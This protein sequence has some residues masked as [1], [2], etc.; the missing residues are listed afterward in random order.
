MDSTCLL[1]LLLLPLLLIG[2]ALGNGAQE[3]PGSPAPPE[4]NKA[5]ICLLSPD[6]GPCRARIPSYYYDRYTQSCRMFFYGGCQGNA[7]NFETLEDCNE[8]CWRIEKVPKICRLEV[9]EGQC[10]A[11]TGE[12]F[13][14]LSSMT[15]EKFV[16]GGCHSNKNR[17]PDKDTCMGF[18]APKKI[19]SYCH[20]PKDGGLCSANVTRYYFNPRHKACETFTYTGCGGND[21]NFVNMEDCTHACIKAVRKQKN[22]KMPKIVFAHRRVKTW[23]K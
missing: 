16:S 15:C 1:R 19:P 9:S 2:T 7:N 13:F 14:N 11:R 3:A 6:V 20:S 21:N 10:G 4:G 8:A 18:C 12:Y 5:D 17:F 22:K 23:K